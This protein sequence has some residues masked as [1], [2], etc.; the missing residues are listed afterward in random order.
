MSNF[1]YIMCLNVMSGRSLT[2]LNQYPVFPWVRGQ[3]DNTRDID[4]NWRD[5]SR[6]M[7]CLGSEE[8]R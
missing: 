7:G 5:L 3:Y 8:R 2:D 4:R 1:D 6:S